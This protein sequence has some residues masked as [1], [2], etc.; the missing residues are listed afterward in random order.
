MDGILYADTLR[1][2]QHMDIILQERRTARRLADR[3]RYA[4]RYAAPEEEWQY[5]RMIDQAERL[6]RYFQ[7]MSELVDDMGLTL[8][9]FSIEIRMLLEGSPP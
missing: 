4:R 7:A 5:D 1:L 2:Q 3:L 6:E 8:G 9:R